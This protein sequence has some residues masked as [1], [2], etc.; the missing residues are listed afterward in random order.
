MNSAA[1][2]RER[3]LLAAGTKTYR[4]GADFAEPLANLDR[5]PDALQCVVETLSELG[6]ESELTE[7]RKYLL[8]PGL[9]RVEGGGACGGRARLR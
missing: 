7:T 6:Y 2:S 4:H 5:V 8:N 1:G 9:Q 3:V